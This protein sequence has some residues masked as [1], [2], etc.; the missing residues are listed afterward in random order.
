M[1]PL[2]SSALG[3]LVSLISSLSTQRILKINQFPLN[4]IQPNQFRDN[5]SVKPTRKSSGH[6]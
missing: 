2:H 6:L 5:L 4:R 1:R 3:S